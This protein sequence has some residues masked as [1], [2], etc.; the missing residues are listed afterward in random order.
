[1]VR[2]DSVAQW[3]RFLTDRWDERKGTGFNPPLVQK[4]KRWWQNKK[5]TVEKEK[6]GMES[7]DVPPFQVERQIMCDPTTQQKVHYPKKCERRKN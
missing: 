3:L 5:K 7:S 2:I 4:E 6:H 1:M